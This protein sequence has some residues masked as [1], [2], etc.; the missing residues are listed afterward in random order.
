VK[1]RGG[2]KNERMIKHRA[3]GFLQSSGQKFSATERP[4]VKSAWL[5]LYITFPA[6]CF[7]AETP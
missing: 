5:G 2:S 3:I 4:K 6:K 1:E 7:H